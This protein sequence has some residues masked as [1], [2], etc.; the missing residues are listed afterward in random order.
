MTIQLAAAAAACPCVPVW[1]ALPSVTPHLT[2]FLLC[3]LQ[4]L[5]L[6][7]LWRNCPPW[8]GVYPGQAKPSTTMCTLLIAHWWVLSSPVT[9]I[10]IIIIMKGGQPHTHTH[11]LWHKL[12]VCKFMS[13]GWSYLYNHIYS[14]TFFLL[15][16]QI[17]KKFSKL[18]KFFSLSIFD[19]PWPDPL[20]DK[21]NLFFRPSFFCSF[22]L[23]LCMQLT[24]RRLGRWCMNDRL[25]GSRSNKT[26]KHHH[27]SWFCCSYSS[28]LQTLLNDVLVTTFIVC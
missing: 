16:F 14:N 23:F 2:Y 11:N 28:S 4:I 3:F 22:L 8:E 27:V 7:C 25:I 15:S 20:T 17:V 13:R 26:D 1:S 5:V 18:I 6:S 10:I 19:V 12:T 9:E 21:T 24:K